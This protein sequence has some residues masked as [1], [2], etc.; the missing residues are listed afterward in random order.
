MDYSIQIIT[1]F[2]LYLQTHGHGFAFLF[3]RQMQAFKTLVRTRMGVY[4]IVPLTNFILK[5]QVSAFEFLI[6][7]SITDSL[8]LWRPPP[9]RDELTNLPVLS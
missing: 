8:Y 4:K 1:L 3:K 6:G 5:I 9:G 2:F 7:C